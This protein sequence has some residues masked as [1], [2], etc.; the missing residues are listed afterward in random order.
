[1]SSSRA[2]RRF[3]LAVAYIWHQN[4]KPWSRGPVAM[5]TLISAVLAFSPLAYA[6]TITW[7]LEDVTFAN[8]ETASGTI[9]VDSVL[10]ASGFYPVTAWNVTVGGVPTGYP[11][12]TSGTVSGSGVQTAYFATSLGPVQPQ[13]VVSVGNASNLATVMQLDGYGLFPPGAG[14]TIIPLIVT[15]PTQQES[16]V[17]QYDVGTGEYAAVANLVTG[18]IVQSVPEP[19]ALVL[20]GFG[21]VS[22]LAYAWR[23]RRQTA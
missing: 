15:T 12:A 8:G 22:L 9:E 23:R 6:D 21:A 5:T 20:L 4:L 18:S 7:T 11:T 3:A 2:V 14:P 13:L 17:Y 19:S 1:M 10:D 16:Y